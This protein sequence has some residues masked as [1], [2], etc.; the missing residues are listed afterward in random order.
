MRQKDKYHMKPL[1]R[2]RRLN[3]F[4]ATLVRILSWVEGWNRSVSPMCPLFI[5]PTLYGEF[6][7]GYSKQWL[8]TR[9]TC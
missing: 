6:G 9:C 8:Q 1:F 7:R 4:S 5:Q 2:V 3:W